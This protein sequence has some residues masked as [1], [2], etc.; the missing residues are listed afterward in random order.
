MRTMIEPIDYST[1]NPGVRTLV[2]ELR[3]EHGLD[4]CDSGDGVT[5]AAA[6]MECTLPYRHVFMQVPFAE[7]ERS[8]IGLSFTYPEAHIECTWC[9]GEVRCIIMLLPDGQVLNEEELSWVGC[10]AEGGCPYDNHPSVVHQP[11]CSEE[12]R[13]A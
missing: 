5:N 2:R 11:Y 10:V 6:G 13:D 3:E 8:A 9:P 4:T 1:V 7:M 12:C